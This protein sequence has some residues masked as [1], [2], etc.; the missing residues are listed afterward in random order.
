MVL[1]LLGSAIKKV[2]EGDFSGALDDAA[3]GSLKLLQATNPLAMA[4]E[5]LADKVKEAL[6][7]QIMLKE[8][9]EQKL[10]DLNRENEVLSKQM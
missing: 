5:V 9:N 3:E 1:G 8:T 10:S 4:V 2:F 7:M 6:L